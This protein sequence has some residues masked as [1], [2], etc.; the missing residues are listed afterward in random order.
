MK[1]W[2]HLLAN[3]IGT[4]TWEE[5]TKW[6]NIQSLLR[7]FMYC[8][9]FHQHCLKPCPNWRERATFT[10]VGPVV[11]TQNQ[12]KNWLNFVVNIFYHQCWVW[13]VKFLYKIVLSCHKNKHLKS[14]CPSQPHSSFSIINFFDRNLSI[15]LCCHLGQWGKFS[16]PHCHGIHAQKCTKAPKLLHHCLPICRSDCHPQPK[17]CLL[18]HQPYPQ[19][20]HHQPTRLASLSC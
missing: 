9:H 5:E 11:T 3:I 18:Q 2:E 20:G 10:A 14:Q 15:L 19:C 7:Y 13:V 8:S 1:P 17:Q 16:V 12:C 4:S 6:E